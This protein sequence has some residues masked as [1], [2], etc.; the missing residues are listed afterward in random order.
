MK[1]F[2]RKNND[3]NAYKIEAEPSMTIGELMK[4]VL[5]DL[6]KKSDFEEDIE[7]YIQN[8]NEDL[9]KGKTLDF[10]KVKEGDT[11]FIGMCKRVF[12][13]ISYAGKGFS[14]Q[15][16]PALMLKNLIKKAAEHFGMSDEEVADFQFLLNGNALNDLKIMVGSLTQYSECSVSLVF[17]PKKDINGFLETPEDIL[18]KD[19][20][21]ADY[22]SGEIDGDWGLIN[23]ENGPKWPIYLF[24]VLAKNNEKYYLRFD[25]TDYNKVA[26]T[27]QLWDIVDNQPL[28][29]HKWPNW[30]KRC[31]QV[32]RNWGPLCLYLPCDRIAFNGHH[33]WPAIHPNLVWQP[34]KDSIFKYLNEVYQILN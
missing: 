26:P 22:L 20:E 10:Y 29:Q 4:K 24:W 11:L 32:F 31:Q 27:A 9:D 1:L 7:V 5:P 6:G 8:Q 23:N 30:S 17:G 34:N 28:P 2:F 19:M 3:V 18:K 15:T 13:S 33:D 16:T 25:L 21:N 12:V 14:L